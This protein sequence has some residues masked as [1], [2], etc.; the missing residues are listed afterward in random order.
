MEEDKQK[1]NYVSETLLKKRKINEKAAVEAAQKREEL[2]KKS[3]RAS[4]KTTFKRADQ[5]IAERLKRE[6]E[7][8]RLRAIRK[9]RKTGKVKRPELETP[10]PSKVLLVIRTRTTH[11]VH[12]T[13]R[14]MLRSM[15]L[16]S[17]N[18]AV[19]VRLNE[20]TQKK[21]K[22]VLP[23]IRYG[24]PNL[25]TVRDL[26][27]KRGYTFSDGQ[28]KPISDNV[29]IEEKLG[30]YGMIC[31]ED[32]I[33]EIVKCGEHFDQAS[34]F[35]SPFKLHEPVGGWR[36]RRLKAHIAATE[37]LAAYETD[38]NKLVESMN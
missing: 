9:E 37:G 29:M 34:R 28:L 27:L 20:R 25:A 30:E 5:F 36:E 8:Q 10:N 1:L 31:V 23:Y 2:R 14:N 6:K 32:I 7:A 18:T 38:V 4:L 22:A 3:K 21:L 24:E 15:R 26:L 33:H 16:G 11:N 17:M 13:I 19:F 12:P 35:L